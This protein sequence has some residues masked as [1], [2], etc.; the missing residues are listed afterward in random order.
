MPIGGAVAGAIGAFGAMGQTRQSQKMAREQMAFQERMSSTAAQR[1]VADFRAAG[2][3]PALAYGHQASSPQGAMGEAENVAGEGLSSAQQARALSQQLKIAREQHEQDVKKTASETQL[4][5]TLSGTSAQQG[6]LLHTQN[7]EALRHLEFQR[8]LE[9]HSKALLEAEARLA[10]LQIPGMTNTANWEE[11]IGKL[12]PGL[13][14]ARALAE[15][16][17]MITR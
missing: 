14:S 11:Q 13:G 7:R 6:N 9:P 16:L 3:N 15:I 5:R 10:Q 12:R 8:I 4:N 17:K 1:A 2:L